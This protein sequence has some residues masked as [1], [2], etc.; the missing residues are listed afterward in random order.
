VNT[1]RVTTTATVRRQYTV[2]AD[3]LTAARDKLEEF[4][5]GHEVAHDACIWFGDVDEDAEEVLR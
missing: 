4:I 3:T 1:Y 2:R 5:D